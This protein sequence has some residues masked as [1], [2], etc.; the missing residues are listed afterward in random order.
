MLFCDLGIGFGHSLAPPMAD[1]E[2][3]DMVAWKNIEVR[4]D[5]DQFRRP[6]DDRAGFFQYFAIESIFDF[7]AVLDASTGKMPTRAIAVAN[8]EHARVFID[9]D[10]LGTQR[11]DV[12]PIE[13]KRS[14][15][16]ENYV[17]LQP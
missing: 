2:Q 16:C 10:P 6:G 15:A 14:E 7:F 3:N 8:E 5:S 13:E 1:Q 9:D 4:I 17:G 11:D 12:G